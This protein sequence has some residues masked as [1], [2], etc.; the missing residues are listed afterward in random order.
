MA[1]RTA[2]DRGTTA[3]TLARPEETLKECRP[4]ALAAKDNA[5]VANIDAWIA[6]IRKLAAEVE[7]AERKGKAAI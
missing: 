1:D 2:A 7:A 3:A 6:D 4:L 5:E